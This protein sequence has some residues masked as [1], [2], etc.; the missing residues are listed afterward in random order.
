MPVPGSCCLCWC[1]RKGPGYQHLCLIW[2]LHGSAAEGRAL[3][4]AVCVT[5]CVSVLSAHR[6]WLWLWLYLGHKL[7]FTTGWTCTQ[8]SRT[9]VPGRGLRSP[10]YLARLQQLGGSQSEHPLTV[11]IPKISNMEVFE[12]EN[13]VFF[14]DAYWMEC[15]RDFKQKYSNSSSQTFGINIAM[16]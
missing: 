8:E 16:I 7:S 5:R 6:Q 15:V 2:T 13:Q 11:W 12:F 10:G 9:R 3:S 14:I 4:A 1:K